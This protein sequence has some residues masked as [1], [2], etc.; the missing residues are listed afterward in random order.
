M[1]PFHTHK[2]VITAAGDYIRRPYWRETGS[3]VTIYLKRCETCG[4]VRTEEIEGHFT[5]EELNGRR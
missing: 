3:D 2:W 5:K 4:D 1:W